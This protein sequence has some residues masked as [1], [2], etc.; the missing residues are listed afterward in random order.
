MGQANEKLVFSFAVVGQGADIHVTTGNWNF[1]FGDNIQAIL[2]TN[3]GSLFGILTQ[4][5]TS[6]EQAKTA[7]RENFRDA[8]FLCWMADRLVG[9]E[10]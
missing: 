5:F 6:T 2:D 8:G 4:E 10:N 1:V 7:L 3:L 9:R